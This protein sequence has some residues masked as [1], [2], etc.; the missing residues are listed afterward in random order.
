MVYTFTVLT[1]VFCVNRRVFVAGPSASVFA[2]SGS[3]SAALG[4][5]FVPR[6]GSAR[7][8]K[9]CS[10]DGAFE[11]LAT[12]S[13]LLCVPATRSSISPG[14]SVFAP[15]PPGGS[16]FAPTTPLGSPS[17]VFGGGGAAAPPTEEPSTG[18]TGRLHIL[19]SPL[20]S[21]PR[22]Q[23]V[24][25]AL[26]LLVS[27]FVSALLCLVLPNCLLP[28]CLGC[29]CARLLFALNHHSK[30]L[31]LCLARGYAEDALSTPKR[32]A[33]G[34][35]AFA[36]KGPLG[37]QPPGTSSG[38]P[39]SVFAPRPPGAA[40][41]GASPFTLAASAAPGSAGAG[42]GASSIFAPRAGGSGGATGSVFASKFAGK[43]AWAT[44]SQAGL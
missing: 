37:A 12:S 30:S 14:G 4:G 34:G 15:K 2:P 18:G 29:S 40:P 24:F 20:H 42:E 8:R 6:E 25:V 21:A 32:P 19:P 27:N 7:P 26:Y 41:S 11:D 9:A 28:G 1:R 22:V 17:S 33:A 39:V 35:S 23:P 38:A 43:P 3:P 31:T 10:Q 5:L 44:A 36:F 13:F 16:V